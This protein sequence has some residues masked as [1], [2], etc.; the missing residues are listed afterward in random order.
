MNIKNVILILVVVGIIAGIA[1]GINYLK[2]K[3]LMFGGLVAQSELATNDFSL[4]LP[5]GWQRAEAGIGISAMAVNIEE[6]VT[7]PAAQKINF[8]TYLA[9]VYDTLQNRTLGDYLQSAKNGLR[10]AVPSVVFAKEEELSVNGRPTFTLEA[11]LTQQGV[12]FYVLMAMIKGEGDDVW[13]MS[14]NTVKDSWQ[15][16]KKEFY[17]TIN[18]FTLKKQA[19]N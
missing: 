14:F 5:K 13:V 16:Y 8:K 17:N 10:Q 7:D 3:E 18:S 19:E 2:R 1:F 15:E 6:N 12:N 4:N 11:E 9:V